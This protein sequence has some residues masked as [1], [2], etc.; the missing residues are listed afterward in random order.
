MWL[1]ASLILAVPLTACGRSG[2]AVGA[3]SPSASPVATAA[4]TGVAPAQ[5]VTD[6][7]RAYLVA[8]DQA[9]LAGAQPD[10]LAAWLR[11]G[12]PAAA[13]E[14]LVATGR[15]L[16]VARHGALYVDA[17]TRVSPGPV[18]FFQ[19]TQ[20]VMASR[21][22]MGRGLTRAEVICRTSTRLTAADGTRQILL[23]DHVLTL[24]AG[25]SGAWLVYQ[26]DYVDAQQAEALAAAG[27]PSWQ[28]RA[29]HQRVRDL[30]RVRRASATA[31]GTMRAFISLLG[32]RRY[33]EAGL[34][35]DPAFGGTARALGATL[36][37]VRLVSAVPNGSSSPT[38]TV[39][40]VTLRVQ[41]RLALWNEGLNVR[42]VTLKRAAGGAWRISAID[43]GP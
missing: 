1:I 12:S 26:D 27:A 30:A 14:P 15:A 38:K 28:V 24:V 16:V 4:P 20:P 21:V 8:R 13:V 11:P 25:S 36:R 6:A 37:S 10:A 43:T 32:A 18:A 31:T 2:A 29:A 9:V 34:C 33:V 7:A 19:G 39:L 22:S 3:S 42:F 35:L 17:L 5:A 23:A 41:S 40:R